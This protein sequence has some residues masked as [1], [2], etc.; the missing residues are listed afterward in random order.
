MVGCRRCTY[1]SINRLTAYSQDDG[2]LPVEHVSKHVHKNLHTC[3]TP[4]SALRKM[5]NITS[6]HQ[7]LCKTLRRIHLVSTSFE[8]TVMYSLGKKRSLQI[9]CLPFAG[10]PLDVARVRCAQHRELQAVPILLQGW[11][12]PE[13]AVVPLLPPLPRAS[14]TPVEEGQEVST[15]V[16]GV[17]PVTSVCS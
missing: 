11:W 12:V 9:S 6:R 13:Q 2:R 15:E 14:S 10:R 17:S 5:E 1:P 3:W 8:T 7:T 4:W 16:G